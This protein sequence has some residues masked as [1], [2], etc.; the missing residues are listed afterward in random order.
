[1]DVFSPRPTRKR[2]LAAVVVLAVAWSAMYLLGAEMRGMMIGTLI[3][4]LL[5]GTIGLLIWAM[6]RGDASGRP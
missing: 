1:M 6:Q 4:L 5:V 2:A 3:G